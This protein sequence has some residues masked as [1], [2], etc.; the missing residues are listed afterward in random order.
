MGAG[1]GVGRVIGTASG[2]GL[3]GMN[4]VLNGFWTA[5]S[6]AEQLRQSMSL[7]VHDDSRLSAE[8]IA[9]RFQSLAAGGRA[10]YF[11][12]MMSGDRDALLRSC[13]LTPDELS[14]VQADVLLIHGREDRP[15]PYRE[16]ALH[17]FEH[18]PRC[19]LALLGRCGH[20]PMLEHTSDVLALAFNHLDTP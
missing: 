12:D 6:S 14:M 3:P 5:P 15:V 7:A 18:L 2:G 13:R 9:T 8:Q 11:R 19:T 16:S 20:N 1:G 17:L 4:D 10:S